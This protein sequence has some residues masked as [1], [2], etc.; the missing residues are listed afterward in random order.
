MST[1]LAWMAAQIPVSTA[2]ISQPH[3]EGL[4]QVVWRDL[5]DRGPA[6]VYEIAVRIG[7]DRER[8]RN[9]IYRLMYRNAVR[10]AMRVPGMGS[11]PRVVW[12]ALDYRGRPLGNSE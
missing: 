8:T 1:A 4:Q 12:V 7:E 9:A 6:T 5:V 10:C 3:G 2:T 11:L